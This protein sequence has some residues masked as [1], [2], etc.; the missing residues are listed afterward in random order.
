MKRPVSFILAG[1]VLSLGLCQPFRG[2]LFLRWQPAKP[3]PGNAPSAANHLTEPKI[4]PARLTAAQARAPR[5]VTGVAQSIAEAGRTSKRPWDHGFLTSLRNR[6]EGDPIR[7]ELINGQ[8]ASGTIGSLV[9]NAQEVSYVF[10]LLAQPQAGRFFFQRQTRPGVAGSFVGVI[11]FAAGATAYRIEPTGPE[12]KPELVER[13]L[14]RI[15]CLGLAAP[16]GPAVSQAASR[17]TSS[18]NP[19]CPIPPYQNGII[20]LESL[21][22]ASAVIYL[23]FEGGYT[24]A[25]GGIAYASPKLSN[26]WIAEIWARVKEDFLPF[27]I[28]VTTDL[29]VFQRA[30]EGS[31]QHVIITP[32]TTAAPG[33]GGIAYIGSFNWTGDTPC[34][35]FNLGGNFCAQSCSHEVGHTLGL[36]HEGLQMGDSVQDYYSG[37]GAGETS[38][39]PIMG[40]SY[41]AS[42]GQ[43]CKGEYLHADNQEDQLDRIAT[44]NNNVSYRPDDAGDTLAT[45]RFLQVRQDGTVQAE[46]IIE[47]TDDTDA[48]RFS[49]G[50]GLV[51]LRANPASLSPNLAVCV[52]LRDS[53]DKLLLRNDPQ[54]TLWAALATNLPPGTYTFNVSGAGRNDPLTNGFSSYA[55]LGYY[56]ISGSVAN[57]Q[58][59]AILRVR[60]PQQ[61]NELGRNPDGSFMLLS[62]DADGGQ[63][64][65]CDR[66]NFILQ[67]SE[68]L[69]AWRATA[70]QG[71]LSNG[72]LLFRDQEATNLAARFYRVIEN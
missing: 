67:A 40:I 18:D 1:I 12:G 35:V 34:W 69:L 57:A 26:A 28:N 47:R 9:K 29:A 32:T 30:P 65:D 24:A 56:C 53:Q 54:P 50:G 51:A 44:G 2:P 58:S 45:A 62:A 66:D 36:N 8:F 42:V 52:A 4:A 72:M 23:D 71:V 6:K 19:V 31:R 15:K 11:E 33:E 60:T 64:P 38:W 41:Y 21:P 27:N 37:Q 5:H 14:S 17:S 48:Y 46:G 39:A 3:T 59:N 43:W 7:F 70:N 22:G 61:L 16:G 63:I 68:D 13:P 55:S 20:A 49:T 25:W 10:G